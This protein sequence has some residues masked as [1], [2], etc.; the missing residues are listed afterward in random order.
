MKNIFSLLV[1]GF[2]FQS[3]NVFAGTRECL[4][5]FANNVI[6]CGI[7]V[8]QQPLTRAQKV[9]ALKV[10]VDNVTTI[11]NACLNGMNQCLNTC[12]ATYDAST[13]TCNQN[14]DPA[15]CAGNAYCEQI[16]IQNRTDC[17][18]QAL[19]TF[20]TCKANCN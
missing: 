17:N 2:L 13:L 16:L 5:D 8:N 9:Q 10:C 6:T 3:Q 12:Q 15:Q 18:T 1:L 11:K 19:G 14:N 7:T 4:R 20:D